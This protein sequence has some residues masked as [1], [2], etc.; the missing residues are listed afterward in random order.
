MNS[1]N[2]IG[3]LTRDPELRHTSGGKP[4][5][6]F[7]I[8]VDN[9]KEQDPFFFSVVA[10]EKTAENVAEY[11]KKGTLVAV[12]GRLIQEKYEKRTAIKIQAYPHQVHFLSHPQGSNDN[13]AETAEAAQGDP[14]AN[15]G[16]DPFAHNGDP[17]ANPFSRGS[18]PFD[19]ADPFAGL[20]PRKS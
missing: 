5:V 19:A 16:G 3:R 11:C 8:A 14:F 20:F 1:V 13:G 12:S 15:A 17:F 18:S 9:G 6:N 7:V 10:W 4:V 2:I